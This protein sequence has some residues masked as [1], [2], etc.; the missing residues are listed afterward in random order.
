MKHRGGLAVDSAPGAGTRITVYLPVAAGAETAPAPEAGAVRPSGT[1]RGG[2]LIVDDEPL[3]RAVVRRTLRRA[4]Y[5]VLEAVDGAD[6]VEAYTRHR[7]EIDLVLLDMAMP[8]MG[9]AAC[10]GH[11]RAIDPSARVLLA[12]GFAAEAEANACL[13]SGALGFLDKPFTSAALLA[14]V[15]GALEPGCPGVSSGA[16]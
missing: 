16:A 1:G 2:I 10:F 14:A 5:F 11:L 13:R 3:V 8:V 15:A 7:A 12:S 4:G 6:G 9:G